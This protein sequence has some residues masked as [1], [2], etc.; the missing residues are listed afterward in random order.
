MACYIDYMKYLLF[1]IASMCGLFAYANDLSMFGLKGPV[2]SVCIIMNDAGLEW[3]TEF[4]FDEKGLLIEIDGVEV[5]C[6]RDS[7]D[8][9]ASIIVEESVEDDEDAFTTID[10]SLT[11]DTSGYVTKVTAKSGDETWTQ[12]YKYDSK[13]LLT[14][15]VYDGG[16]ENEIRQYVYL[17]FDEYG[18]WTERQERLQSMDSTITQTRN[19]TYLD[20]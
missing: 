4:T 20:K 14:E 8:R 15:L 12:T 3:Q 9:I 18:N 11:Y 19:I 2:D 5:T 1:L 7:K 13:G 17:K 16:E 10:M 6:V